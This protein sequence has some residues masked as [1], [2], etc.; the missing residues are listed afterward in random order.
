MMLILP[1][2]YFFKYCYGSKLIIYSARSVFFMPTAIRIANKYPAITT[3]GK[4][5]IDNYTCIPLKNV[6]GKTIDYSSRE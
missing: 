3:Y 6:A 2:K 5:N 4:E 1:V